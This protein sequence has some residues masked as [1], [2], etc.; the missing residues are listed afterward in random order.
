[1]KFEIQW[2]DKVG[3]KSRPFQDFIQKMANRIIQGHYRYG[4][5]NKDQNYMT[6]IG[7][8]LKAYRYY[9][10][11]EQLYNIAN[12]CWLESQAPENSKFHCDTAALSVTR[13]KLG[14]SR[15]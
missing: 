3:Q 6:R 4:H 5:P 8:E 15:E 12:Y 14:G 10:N 9:G 1:M 2:S 13:F 7:L 11:I